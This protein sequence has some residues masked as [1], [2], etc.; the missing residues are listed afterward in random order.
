MF[1]TWE[2]KTSH[3]SSCLNVICVLYEMTNRKSH[4]LV[5]HVDSNLMTLK[6]LIHIPHI[7]VEWYLENVNG[8]VVT[9]LD[10][11]IFCEIRLM[12]APCSRRTFSCSTGLQLETPSKVS[13][14][15]AFSGTKAFPVVY[16]AFRS[17]SWFSGSHSKTPNSVPTRY[18][19]SRLG[20]WR[21]LD[22]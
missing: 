4:C 8:T 20:P 9:G 3:C 17:A 7:C 2:E 10:P 1:S 14:A 19:T 6:K 16:L 21:F 15:A 13:K 5:R 11:S 18:G 12:Q 22:R